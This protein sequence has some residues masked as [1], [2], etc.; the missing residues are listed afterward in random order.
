MVMKHET[1]NRGFG[2]AF[3]IV[4]FT[5]GLIIIG[6]IMFAS[7]SAVHKHFSY[8]HIICSIYVSHI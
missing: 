8:F 2:Q 7:V 4:N 5:L 3:E 6:L 1:K